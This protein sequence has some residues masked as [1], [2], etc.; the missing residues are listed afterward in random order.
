MESTFNYSPK[1]KFEI[2]TLSKLLSFL[3]KKKSQLFGNYHTITLKT[4]VKVSCCI[5]N[6]SNM[7]EQCPK[8]LYISDPLCE[9]HM[10]IRTQERRNQTNFL[11]YGVTNVSQNEKIKIQKQQTAIS[12]GFQWSTQKYNDSVISK[13]LSKSW[14]YSF[15]ICENIPLVME[16]PIEMTHSCGKKWLKTPKSHLEQDDPHTKGQGC[17]DCYQNSIRYSK[18][19][20]ES[21]VI[22]RFGTRFSCNALPEI[23]PNNHTF[24]PMECCNHGPYLT[25]IGS[26]LYGSG[27]CSTCSK[28]IKTRKEWIELYENELQI[29]KISFADDYPDDKL[30]LSSDKVPFQCLQNT[31]HPIWVSVINNVIRSSGCP[32]CKYKTVQIIIRFLQKNN[33]PFRQEIT[34]SDCKKFRLLKFDFCIENELFKLII[35]LDG[36]Q[37]FEQIS[38]WDSPNETLITDTYKM[39]KAILHGYKYIRICQEDVIKGGEEFLNEYVLPD[40]LSILKGEE[41]GHTFISTNPNLYNAHIAMYEKGEP[42]DLHQYIESSEDS[43]DET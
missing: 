34:F 18:E 30:I 16:T 7:C 19:E 17:T 2:N 12:N 37:H 41:T 13:G 31:E 21:I 24:I 43:Q 15:I 4:F 35:E 1:T 28:K 29:R 20:I 11:N 36:P 22:Q 40:I 38:N 8:Q 25:R 23:I 39:Q 32:H 6:C 9:S 3:D 10:K 42:I 33:L 27:G 14:T 5:S 26:L